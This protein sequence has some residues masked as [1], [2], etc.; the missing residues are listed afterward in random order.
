MRSKKSEERDSLFKPEVGTESCM[1]VIY[2]L[3]QGFGFCAQ[4]LWFISSFTQ[5]H[6]E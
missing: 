5:M 4:V 1:R 2:I 3:K 6:K